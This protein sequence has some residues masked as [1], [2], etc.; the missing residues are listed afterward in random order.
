METPIMKKLERL[1]QDQQSRLQGKDITRDQE[2]HFLIRA[3]SSIIYN[4]SK[5]VCI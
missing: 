4:I 1:Y 3:N 2:G 5:C